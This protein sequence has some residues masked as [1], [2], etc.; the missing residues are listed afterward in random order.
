[1][2]VQT[3]R[4]ED[5]RLRVLTWGA[6][7]RHAVVL[8]GMSASY[9]TLAP[10]IRLLRRLGYATH[11]IELPGT[12]LGPPLR[13]DQARF[14]QL[15]Q[16]VAGALDSLGV[17]HAVFV[18]HSLG[19]GIALHLAL[20][21][22][23]LVEGLVL[24]APVGLGR[25]LLW[26]YKLFGIPLLGRAL[27]RPYRRASAGYVRRFLVGDRRRDDAHFIG[28]LLRM[29]RP[30]L[31]KLQSM[32]AIIWANGPERLQRWVSLVLPGGEQTTFSVRPRLTELRG[33]PMLVLWGQQDRVI[34]A[35]DTAG[36]RSAGLDAEI[37]VLPGA[38]HMLPL[39]APAWT[40]AHLARFL[41]RLASAPARSAA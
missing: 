41:V 17:R 29:E 24:I 12:S 26:T 5:Y 27:M 4:C 25:S 37:R 16:C 35:G 14:S 36:C 32:R 28:T 34:C 15:A 21:R 6:G 18:G 3:V 11:L 31:A 13:R 19:G 8:P 22:R 20:A 38:G 39:E 10:Q 2:R 30:S 1:M 23:D 7:P 40:I 33:I 9:H